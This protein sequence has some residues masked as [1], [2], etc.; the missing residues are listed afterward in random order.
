MHSR[1]GI[2]LKRAWWRL[3]EVVEAVALLALLCMH[4]ASILCSPVCIPFNTKYSFPEIADV[5][6]FLCEILAATVRVSTGWYLVASSPCSVKHLRPDK[7]EIVTFLLGRITNGCIVCAVHVSV[8]RVSMLSM[9]VFNGA[10][11]LT[12]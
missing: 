3:C 9:R 6:C 10:C 7:L 11:V 12:I 1:Y 8:L 4:L 2:A 5:R